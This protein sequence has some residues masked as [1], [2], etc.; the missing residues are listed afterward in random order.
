MQRIPII[1]EV[2]TGTDDAICIT[3]ALL[4]QDQLDIKAFT[5]VCGNVTLDKTSQNTRNVVSY[6]G[7]DPV[8]YT[9]LDVYKRQFPWSLH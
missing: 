9:H 1:I 5:S 3:A 4:H 2:D 7:S 8:S 6:L